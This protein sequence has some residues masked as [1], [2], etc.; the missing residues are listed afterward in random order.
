MKPSGNPKS[1]FWNQ[2]S[3]LISSIR[4]ASEDEQSE[5][6]NILKSAVTQ[7]E[8]KQPVSLPRP[9]DDNYDP[10]GVVLTNDVACSDNYSVTYCHSSDPCEARTNEDYSASIYEAPDLFLKDILS[11]AFLS[12]APSGQENVQGES[13]TDIH[14]VSDGYGPVGSIVS[15]STATVQGSSVGP[16][17]T[18]RLTRRRLKPS[19]SQTLSCPICHHTFTEWVSLEQ[20]LYEGHTNSLAPVCWRCQGVFDNHAVLLAHECFDWGR[21]NL[22]CQGIDARRING[23]T[24]RRHKALLLHGNKLGFPENGVFLRRRCGLC[25]KSVTVFRSYSEFQEHKQIL[26]PSYRMGTGKSHNESRGKRVRNRSNKAEEDSGDETPRVD[27]LHPKNEVALHNCV[28]RLFERFCQMNAVHPSHSSEEASATRI[29]QEQTELLHPSS[30][31]SE[32]VVSDTNQPVPNAVNSS[33]ELT[34]SP[35]VAIPLPTDLDDPVS[36]EKPI[37]QI[38]RRGRTARSLLWR[39]KRKLSMRRVRVEAREKPSTSVAVNSA[40]GTRRSTTRRYVCRCCSTEFRVASRLRA[41]H[42]FQHGNIPES[43]GGLSPRPGEC[44]NAGPAPKSDH[45]TRNQVKN[46]V[47]SSIEQSSAKH[48]KADIEQELLDTHASHSLGPMVRFPESLVDGTSSS[49]KQHKENLSSIAVISS[50]SLP[51]RRG[52][53]SS[54]AHTN[55]KNPAR[56]NSKEQNGSITQGPPY[57]CSF[58]SRQYLTMYSLRRH[59]NQSHWCQYRLYCGYC[60]YRTNERAA[61]DEHLARH[62]HVRQFACPFCDAKFIVNR[63][64]KDH[65]AFKHTTER[66]HYCSVCGMTFKTAGTLSRHR[67]TH[68]ERELHQCSLCSSTF[69][70]LSNLKRHITNAHMKST[71]RSRARLT[72]SRQVDATNAQPE[73][74][75]VI[76]NGQDATGSPMSSITSPLPEAQS[77]M[78][79]SQLIVPD[80]DHALE[81]VLTPSASFSAITAFNGNMT[82]VADG[83]DATTFTASANSAPSNTVTITEDLRN[84]VDSFRFEVPEHQPE[85][86]PA[87]PLTGTVSQVLASNLAASTKSS[88]SE[89]TTSSSQ[90]PLA[91]H[92]GS[93]LYTVV[94]SQSDLVTGQDTVSLTTGDDSNEPTTESASLGP[95][96]VVD[97][98]DLDAPNGLLEVTDTLNDGRQ[99]EDNCVTSNIQVD[100]DSVHTP[101]GDSASG[102]ADTEDPH[103]LSYTSQALNTALMMHTTSP[104]SS[105]NVHESGLWANSESGVGSNLCFMFNSTDSVVQLLHINP[106]SLEPTASTKTLSKAEDH[107][108]ILSHDNSIVP[109]PTDDE[110]AVQDESRNLFGSFPSSPMLVDKSATEAGIWRPVESL[111]I[112][113]SDSRREKHVSEQFDQSD[114]VTFDC[115]ILLGS[116]GSVA[117]GSDAL[118]DSPR[119]PSPVSETQFPQPI[120]YSP[121]PSNSSDLVDCTFSTSHA[122]HHDTATRGATVV[123][124]NSNTSRSHYEFGQL[125]LADEG[126]SCSTQNVSQFLPLIWCCPSTNSTTFSANAE[127][128]Y[129]YTT[130]PSSPVDFPTG[131]NQ[132]SNFSVGYLIGQNRDPGNLD[133]SD[134]TDYHHHHEPSTILDC[135]QNNTAH[136]TASKTV[137][138]SSSVTACSPISPDDYFEFD[139][140]MP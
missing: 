44:G 133:P 108:E 58:C 118:P 140:N 106:D 65:I 93:G 136:T 1:A 83:T 88:L 98:S 56:E 116:G 24:R 138:T 85:S 15:T 66:N 90:P 119:F 5:I 91:V 109:S 75:E 55:R 9:E 124:S 126:N 42:L 30:N 97:L 64:L 92:S 23:L 8:N 68:G 38:T 26:H 125:L 52:K 41:H 22:P 63:E 89:C 50:R 67:K 40:V 11:S 35:T 13:S 57:E 131:T 7:L 19:R 16:D 122:T 74:V 27:C 80:S 10:D 121:N 78:S 132:C 60:D 43:L 105:E 86:V 53:K 84:D 20:H 96:Y 62:F 82:T 4:S 137:P 70:R 73:Q 28:R 25:F 51:A 47:I 45:T 46:T 6:V 127:T 69:T 115:N 71:A 99:D 120:M 103:L 114:F 94:Y 102:Y 100:V 110:A 81:D 59:E 31:F 33:V 21:V 101:N 134:L 128:H 87:H 32:D 2:L 79:R 104:K 111:D 54:H 107:P 123:S 34:I 39:R 113:T 130:A 95:V 139:V 29:K 76:A 129:V 72:R 61:Y 12:D 49:E 3:G 77:L 14:E 135:E 36:L 17:V 18:Q 112:E 117:P 37:S 48:S